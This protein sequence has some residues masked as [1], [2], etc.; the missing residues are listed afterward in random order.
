MLTFY[1]QSYTTQEGY[2]IFVKLNIVPHPCNDDETSARA[3][4]RV[5]GVD[6]IYRFK[7]LCIKYRKVISYL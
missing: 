2:F 4:I 7:L 3:H 5:T 1:K 6:L